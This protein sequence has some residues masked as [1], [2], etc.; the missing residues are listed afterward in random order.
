MTAALKLP[1]MPHLGSHIDEQGRRIGIVFDEPDHSYHSVRAFSYSF[2][3]EFR[4]SPMHG[5]AYFTRTWESSSDREL[6]KAVHLMALEET[7]SRIAIVDGVRRGA[8]KTE[9]EALQAQGKIVLKPDA[10][11]EAKAISAAIRGHALAGL[12]LKNSICEVSLYW[13]QDGIYCKARP[14]IISITE[15]GIVLGDL[16]N[17]GDCSRNGLIN[18]QISQNAYHLQQAFYSKGIEAILGK[19]PIKKFWTFV[20]TKAPHGVRLFNCTDAMCERGWAEYEAMLPRY[21]QCLE[22]DNWPGYDE[23]EVDA[24][25][26]L[27]AWA[28]E[29]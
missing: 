10:Y 9:V 1:S 24:D 19:P 28:I 11:E 25:L 14:D 12:I 22:T 4:K 21:K 13:M 16:K 2:S 8:V 27:H 26:P 5:K 29:D 17:F 6:F 7:T 20:E 18:Y 15:H 23:A 3:K